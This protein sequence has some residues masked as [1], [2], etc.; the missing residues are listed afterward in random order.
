[1]SLPE[2]FLARPSC[3]CDCLAPPDL[4]LF[5]V[6]STGSGRLPPAALAGPTFRKRPVSMNDAD[7]SRER[8]GQEKMGLVRDD[9]PRSNGPM[10]HH[11]RRSATGRPMAW[12]FVDMLDLRHPN[13]QVEGLEQL[14]G[15]PPSHKILHGPPSMSAG[16]E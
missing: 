3:G 13:Q 15:G 14:V 2:Q 7:G 5:L 4:V 11:S 8:R 6:C 16:V 12:Q 10:H 1:M 9:L